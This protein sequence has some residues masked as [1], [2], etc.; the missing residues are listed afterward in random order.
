MPPQDIELFSN[1]PMAG[2]A[3]NT[4]TVGVM[5]SHA[6]DADFAAPGASINA[7]DAVNKN[8]KFRH[9]TALNLTGFFCISFIIFLTSTQPFFITQ[10]LSIDNSKL[11]NIIGT[12]GV[13]DEL[14]CIIVS[15]LIG[16]FSDKI[17]HLN[18]L[19]NGPKFIVVAGFIS[20]W[21]SF[22]LYG[23][24]PFSSW[25]ELIFP[26]I[27]FA[28]GVTSCMSM[29]PVLLNQLI[30]SDFK[31]SNNLF[32]KFN[33]SQ[34][35][36]NINK[37]GR[38]SAMIGVC[39]GLGAIFS[40][41][42]FLTLP[43]RLLADYDISS[44]QALKLAFVA[45]GFISLLVSLV[46]MGFLY[47]NKATGTTTK[48][49][50]YFELLSMG[51]TKLKL[52]RSVQLASL[53][54]F[55]ARSTSVLIAVFVPLFVY[56]FYHKS[57]KCESGSGSLPKEDCYDG[58]TF[59]AI[60]TGVAQTLSLISSPVWGVLVERIGKTRCL[61]MSSII[62]L[63]GNWLLCVFNIYDP[64]NATTF[65]LVSLIGV[66]QIGTVISSM[67]FISEEND[68]VGS[69]SGVYNLCGGVG[70]L[71]LSRVGGMWSDSWSLGPFFVMGL[72][73]MVLVGVAL[74]R[75]AGASSTTAL[76]LE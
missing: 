31:F 26:R 48:R 17:N 59:A 21:A 67:C 37:N 1:G 13:V 35:T 3:K 7:S 47:S 53:G 44:K 51:I 74:A 55:V 36:T 42:C 54:G 70:I 52:N 23:F 65:I 19:F 75:G 22:F 33:R 25:T 2:G 39:T 50:S 29:V 73:N 12:L 57:G 6:S 5:S 34:P 68:A 56:D 45:I 27:L 38:Y 64:R 58:Y 62:G 46:I 9:L 63:L 76:A 14:T 66:S 24:I 20:I 18:W 28:I 4:G 10:L 32:W 61:V 41:S 40:V 71:V 69:I 43:V 11:G 8:Y 15:P 72:F 16:S 30:Y 60:L 49:P